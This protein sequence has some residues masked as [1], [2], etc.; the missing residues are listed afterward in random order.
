MPA[1]YLSGSILLVAAASLLKKVPNLNSLSASTANAIASSLSLVDPPYSKPKKGAKPT[2][3]QKDE[4][5]AYPLATFTYV[6]TRPDGANVALV[7]QF[8]TFA[9]SSAEQ[10]KG[11]GGSLQFAPLP[12]AIAKADAAA[13]AKL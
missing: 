4:A 10:K 13:V 5:A 11:I 1:G 12:G 2:T 7:K 9:L 3:L 8:I 6:I